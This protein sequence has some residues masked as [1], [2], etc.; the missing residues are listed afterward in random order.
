M[1][2]SAPLCNCRIISALAVYFSVS[3]SGDVTRQSVSAVITGVT[4]SDIVPFLLVLLLL[5][6]LLPHD[7]AMLARSRES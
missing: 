5:L 2:N 6:L 4:L 7:A 3:H 1:Q